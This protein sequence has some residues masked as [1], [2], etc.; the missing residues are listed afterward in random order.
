MLPDLSDRSDKQT[1][2][3]SK[4]TPQYGDDPIV[5]FSFLTDAKGLRNRA[6]C[7]L[8]YTNPETHR[9]I[10]ENLE[11]KARELGFE[12]VFLSAR[13]PALPFYLHLG[14]VPQSREQT[15]NGIRF[16]AMTFDL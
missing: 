16:T 3:F 8:T 9:I 5:P 4:I 6:I 15:I 10:L 1:L 7:Y 14:F 11:C 2:D 13:E 12:K